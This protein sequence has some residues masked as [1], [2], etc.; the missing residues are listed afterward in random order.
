MFRNTVKPTIPPQ[1]SATKSAQ[2]LLKCITKT[3]SLPTPQFAI[4]A[5][6]LRP[7]PHFTINSPP[8]TLSIIY[9]I[10][11]QRHKISSVSKANSLLLTT[12]R[13]Q[14]VKHIIKAHSFKSRV[15][16]PL[17]SNMIENMST[18]VH[19]A[20]LQQMYNDSSTR[21]P[22][23]ETLSSEAHVFR[24]QL[25]SHQGQCACQKSQSS[26]SSF[27]MTSGQRC[28]FKLSEQ[29]VHS[30][31]SHAPVDDN[32]MRSV[33]TLMASMSPKAKN[34]QF[35]LNNMSLVRNTILLGGDS[36]PGTYSLTGITRSDSEKEILR[37]GSK[38]EY[39]RRASGHADSLLETTDEPNQSAKNDGLRAIVTSS[40][41]KQTDSVKNQ[42]VG[43][44]V[45]KNSSGFIAQTIGRSKHP[46]NSTDEFSSRSKLQAEKLAVKST[47][48]NNHNHLFSVDGNDEA[49]KIV[50]STLDN[51][52][53]FQLDGYNE[54]STKPIAAA[55][56]ATH[57]T[58][59]AINKDVLPVT[60]DV[61]TVRTVLAE[62]HNLPENLKTQNNDVTNR[63]ISDKEHHPRT[64]EEQHDSSKPPPGAVSET[65]GA[66]NYFRSDL[67]FRN[68]TMQQIDSQIIN[69]TSS[70]KS[71]D[72][73]SPATSISGFIVA[74]EAYE[75]MLTTSESMQVVIEKASHA[76]T[77][78]NSHTEPL[79][80]RD[81]TASKYT[82]VNTKNATETQN[83]E[84]PEHKMSV[85]ALN[86]SRPASPGMTETLHP[87]TDPVHAALL[88][89]THKAGGTPDRTPT[90]VKQVEYTSLKVMKTAQKTKSSVHERTSAERRQD[91]AD[92]HQY[93][94]TS[95]SQVILGAMTEFVPPTGI[96]PT[97]SSNK[98]NCNAIGCAK[99]GETTK[100]MTGALEMDHT[101]KNKT[102]EKQA[103]HIGKDT[104]DKKAEIG[105]CSTDSPVPGKATQRAANMDYSVLSPATSTSDH[106]YATAELSMRKNAKS[107][108]YEPL[109]KTLR[110]VVERDHLE[111]PGTQ[112]KAQFVEKRTQGNRKT[113]EDQEAVA[114]E[115][116]LSEPG[117]TTAQTNIQSTE[118]TMHTGKNTK[119]QS[120]SGVG[121]NEKSER[122][123]VRSTLHA[124][125]KE[126]T[127]DQESGRRLLLLAPESESDLPKLKHRRRTSPHLYLSGVT[128]VSEDLC[129]S[130]NYTAEM[131]LNLGRG[132]EP[133][134]A[135]PALGNLRVVINLKT[136]NSR[137]NL[138]VTSCCLSPTTQPDLAN[139]TCCLFSR[140]ATEPVGIT[141]LPSALSTSASFTINL[142]QMIN[143]SVV[144][145]HCDLSVCLRNRSDCEREC[146]QQR[147]A[148]PLD[149]PEAIVTNLR[150]RIS[151][152]PMLK[153]LKNSTFLE[154]IDCTQTNL[155][156]GFMS[157]YFSFFPFSDP[158]ELDL[159]LIIVSLVVGSSLVTV[160]L[161]LV[162]LAYR[163][164]AIWPL[165]SAAPP[166]ACCGCMHPGG[167]L[168]LP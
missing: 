105:N 157:D 162:W 82:S 123:N 3:L 83:I 76:E 139:S 79:S 129:G 140:L 132:V 141:L 68:A 100:T 98:A 74:T 66:H 13:R 143:Y 128:E 156:G 69:G 44:R 72:F 97:E 160:L 138:E 25:Q 5:R 102:H 45:K 110:A 21:G 108:T 26:S 57:K 32:R 77:Q 106:D 88:K 115:V 113:S 164:R 40:V 145:L 22:T 151:F 101:A 91:I 54:T 120:Y 133:G 61:A 11:N 84:L 36:L 80:Q 99:S 75:S 90:T 49:N 131:S 41:K 116:I 43:S 86:L 73:V 114:T 87:T 93:H 163:R 125:A 30:D 42:M 63:A 67:K 56:Q 122:Q 142:F 168:I 92:Q 2:L 64:I 15:K 71:N 96:M 48:D 147:S 62:S 50:K 117:A 111:G 37:V 18:S 52:H 159:V 107:L 89:D 78:T 33:H 8:L 85:Q 112:K 20:P 19:P 158:P 58:E 81:P 12:N 6:V 104:A 1:S 47:N 124:A 146:L 127:A 46:A 39:A 149:S 95:M 16:D 152:G 29:T 161:L 60:N 103:G 27:D 31:A 55:I 135:V 10:A 130:G 167:D 35:P 34:D 4:T 155:G 38:N 28:S 9:S 148:F 23:A 121:Q 24:S 134:D 53:L 65:T 153:E 150:N 109:T 14:Q 70:A 7:N 166:R 59:Q 126:D 118:R 51:N 154:A 17:N 94:Q 144:Y 137:V 165:H 136:N 119:T